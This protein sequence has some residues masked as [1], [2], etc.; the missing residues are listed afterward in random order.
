MSVRT[1][2]GTVWDKYLKVICMFI[3]V[4]CCIRYCCGFAD[5]LDNL[6]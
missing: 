6:F 5:S 4:E 3:V 1:G 2:G